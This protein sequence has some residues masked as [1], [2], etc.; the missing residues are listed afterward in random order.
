MELENHSVIVMDQ[1]LD[2]VISRVDNHV[3]YNL[4]GIILGIVSRHRMV[5]VVVSVLIFVL[6]IM[7]LLEMLTGW[8]TG[9]Y[10]LILV[11][12]VIVIYV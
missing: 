1:H 9:I 4:Q 7:R 6:H 2:L 3:I 12:G 11:V 5:H 8:L 10:L